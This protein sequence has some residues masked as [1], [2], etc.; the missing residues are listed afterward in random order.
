MKAKLDN[1]T[2]MALS[3][4]GGMAITLLTGLV[5]STPEQLVGGTWYGYPTSWIIRLVLAPQYN[6][7]SFQA[8]NFVIDVIVWSVV[9]AIVLLAARC[10]TGYKAGTRS[11]I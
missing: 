5:N 7:W 3:V 4:I 1:R 9:V 8:A 6:P 11:R 2:V 10:A